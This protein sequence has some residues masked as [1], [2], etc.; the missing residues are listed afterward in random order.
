[1]GCSKSKIVD[2]PTNFDDCMKV[3]E[4]RNHRWMR[5]PKAFSQRFRL[6]QKKPETQQSQPEPMEIGKGTYSTVYSCVEVATGEI[7][8]CKV[9]SIKRLCAM[10]RKETVARTLSEIR[11]GARILENLGKHENIITLRGFY[12]NKTTIVVVLEY[13]D[14]GELYDH[15]ISRGSFAEAD[16]AAILRSI[17][18]AV[19]HLHENDVVHRDLKPENVVLAKKS[20]Q[21]KIIDFGFSRSLKAR[22]KSMSFIGTLNYCSPEIRR[23]QAYGRSAEVWS[24]GVIAF[25]LLVGYLPFDTSKSDPNYENLV[26]DKED[27]ASISMAARSFVS[28]CLNP[29]ASAR[30]TAEQ[31]TKLPFLDLEMHRKRQASSE[32]KSPSRLR[33]SKKSIRSPTKNY[34]THDG[35]EE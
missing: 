10:Q 7:W 22:Q 34:S 6:M 16:A 13:G 33:V 30:P 35:K 9:V 26:F 24:L 4:P 29:T 25:V 27:W 2:M 15:M 31:I 32:L 12:E 14:G 3:L 17:A 8:A 11:R 20:N 19:S 18:L 21:W 5:L 28:A 23:K 1:M